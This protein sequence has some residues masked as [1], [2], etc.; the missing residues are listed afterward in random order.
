VQ[1][2]FQA[3]DKSPAAVLGAIDALSHIANKPDGAQAI[4]DAKGLD[5][6]LNLLKSDS[7]GIREWA[8]ILVAR[9]AQHK[10][11]APAICAQVVTLLRCLE[12]LLCMCKSHSD[13]VMKFLQLL[14]TP[15]MHCV[16]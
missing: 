13:S 2:S 16:G 7:P 9:L 4:V 1:I 11:I 12:L 5:H 15:W 8:C 14:G 10:F 3:S 6:I